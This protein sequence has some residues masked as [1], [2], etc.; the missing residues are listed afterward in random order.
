MKYIPAVLPKTATL[1]LS[2]ALDRTIHVTNFQIGELNRVPR[3]SVTPGSKGT[4]VSRVLQRFGIKSDAVCCLGGDTG[5]LFEKMLISEGLNISRINTAAPTRMNIK[6]IDE[7]GTCTELNEPNDVTKAECDEVIAKIDE[8]AADTKLFIMGG[9]V[10]NGMSK[11]IYF[12]IIT[13]LKSQK[14][15]CVLDCDGEALSTGIKA[16]PCLIKPNLY[17]LSMLVGKK[18]TSDD[19]II[20][21]ASRIHDEY[22]TN[23]I[24]TMGGDG[25]IF[26]GDAGIFRVYPPKVTVR[27][28]A[29]AG[30]TFLGVFL[31]YAFDTAEN[32]VSKNPETVKRAME[33]AVKAAAIKVSFEG[34]QIPDADT[35]LG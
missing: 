7:N 33:I 2:P 1:T 15:V 3:A 25:A 10:P 5:D 22:K 14:I 23:V 11:S 16:G 18:L 35:L 31:C 8:L 26:V 28:F 12:D 20:D 29:G 19:E 4:N 24:C 9:S 27:G 17:E 13:R 21:S 30:D 32:C 34:T 6:I